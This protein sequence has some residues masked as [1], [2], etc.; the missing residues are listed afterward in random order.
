MV[1][2]RGGEADAALSYLLGELANGGQLRLL[3]NAWAR[4]SG[5]EVRKQIEAALNKGL[6]HCG[7]R[8][9]SRAGE[10]YSIIDLVKRDILPESALVKAAAALGEELCVE[11]LFSLREK[12]SSSRTVK[13][14]CDNALVSAVVAL[15]FAECVEDIAAF[16]SKHA[17][18]EKVRRACDDAMIEA[19]GI[20]RA[21][22]ECYR[23]ADLADKA[24]SAA[25]NAAAT[26]ALAELGYVTEEQ[27][28]EAVGVLKDC[29][30]LASLAAIH[31]DASLPA[32]HTRMVVAAMMDAMDVAATFGWRT[33]GEGGASYGGYDEAPFRAIVGDKNTH[34]TYPEEVR[35]KAARL[36]AVYSSVRDEPPSLSEEMSD[37]LGAQRLKLKAAE[38]SAIRYLIQEHDRPM[39]GGTLSQGTVPR[40]A[41]EGTRTT[42]PGPLR[43]KLRDPV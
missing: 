5:P 13:E 18:P 29:G 39:R 40:P 25:V 34:T 41:N 21:K 28:F 26:A 43:R 15:R 7:V 2:T 22:S 24:G 17:L 36:L 31:D 4:E 14:A 10:R 11:E 33:S 19:I 9:S 32:R 6:D 37:R 3:A 1:E 8:P 23:I 30:K 12:P 16:S 35:L 27:F 42:G 20:W 38:A